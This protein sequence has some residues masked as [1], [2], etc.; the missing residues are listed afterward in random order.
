[1]AFSLAGCEWLKETPSGSHGGWAANKPM[2]FEP[3]PQPELRVMKAADATWI[4]PANPAHNAVPME[5]KAEKMGHSQQAMAEQQRLQRLEMDV[6]KMQGDLE[7]I[8]P[9]LQKIVAHQQTQQAQMDQQ[10]LMAQQSQMAAQQGMHASAHP[11]SLTPTGYNQ[12][13]ASTAKPA[14]MPVTPS[15]VVKSVR[16][17]E[18][19]NKTRLVLDS[20]APISYKY[21]VNAVNN[22]LV[23]RL[24]NSQWSTQTQQVIRTSNV[25][26]G[27]SVTQN[28]EAGVDLVVSLKRPVQV[29]TEMLSPQTAGS[30]G[31]YRI[32]FDLV[33]L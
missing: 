26:T 5:T 8:V 6:D 23:I 27:Y 2:G 7:M 28:T 30:S 31:S 24:P 13:V 10:M 1:M 21:T 19:T 29:S 20:T 33:S 14:S 11:S 22:T 25:V 17:G 18:H 9:A 4:E 12:P 15:S 32:F 16:F 3:A